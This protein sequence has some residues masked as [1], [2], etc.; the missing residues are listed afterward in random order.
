MLA[1]AARFSSPAVLLKLT[2]V[3]NAPAPAWRD[4][5]TVAVQAIG[6]RLFSPYSAT[7]TTWP[8]GR[9][10]FRMSRAPVAETSR[11]AV[12]RFG[13]RPSGARKTS[14]EVAYFGD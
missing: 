11:T 10:S 6:S 1:T 5:T 7:P 9:L 14:T 2:P 4:H 3:M 8:A 13:P 12:A